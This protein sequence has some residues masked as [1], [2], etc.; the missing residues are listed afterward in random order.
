[1]QQVTKYLPWIGGH[2]LAA[3]ILSFSN[4]KLWYH[5]KWFRIVYT[6]FYPVHALI[7]GLIIC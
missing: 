6:L 7:I 4:G 5:E 1:M 3:L 2:V